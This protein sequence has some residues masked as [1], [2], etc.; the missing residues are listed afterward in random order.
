VAGSQRQCSGFR[1]VDHVYSCYD[2]VVP[3]VSGTEQTAVFVPD[4]TWITA[5]A[6]SSGGY[7]PG[8]VGEIHLSYNTA[9]VAGSSG[10]PVV[11]ATIGLPTTLFTVS[12]SSP[13][14]FKAGQKLYFCVHGY[15]NVTADSTTSAGVGVSF[16]L[17]LSSAR[18]AAS[19]AIVS[20]ATELT[21][22]PDLMTAPTGSNVYVSGWTRSIAPGSTVAVIN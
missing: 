13:Y 14:V 8:L 1:D 18:A 22:V 4:F 12:S 6:G 19:M 17:S 9:G 15:D 10:P 5:L 21:T 3:A 16:H 20:T 7:G 2:L 11:V